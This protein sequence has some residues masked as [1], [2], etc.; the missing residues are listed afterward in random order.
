MRE[1]FS[2]LRFE[3]HE[4]LTEAD[5][6]IAVATMT[7]HHTGVFNNIAPTGKPI[8]HKQVHIFTLA[9][10]QITRHRAVRDD[11]AAASAR[12]APIAFRPPADADSRDPG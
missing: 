5:T 9:D 8:E 11:L 2:N 1:A 4:T 6:V 12:L 7:G 3:L 10:G